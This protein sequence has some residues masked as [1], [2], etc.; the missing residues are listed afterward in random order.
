MPLLRPLLVKMKLQLHSPGQ[1]AIEPDGRIE[2]E[3]SICRSLIGLPLAHVSAHIRCMPSSRCQHTSA[4]ADTMLIMKPVA[5]SAISA[6]QRSV[7]RSQE[8][9]SSAMSG[10][11][12]FGRLMRESSSSAPRVQS[13]RMQTTSCS[14]SSSWPTSGSG[15]WQPHSATAHSAQRQSACSHFLQQL[16]TVLH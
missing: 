2:A 11:V 16:T 10:V 1:S 5:L 3:C 8:I 12:M 7:L 14:R 13:R 9:T 6:S 15:G 4:H